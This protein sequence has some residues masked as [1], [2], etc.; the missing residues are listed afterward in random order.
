MMIHESR[1]DLD[2][3]SIAVLARVAHEMRQPLSAATA[4]VTLIKDD[5]DAERVE[6]AYRVLKYQ[7]ARLFRLLDDL[8]VTATIGSDVTTLNKERVDL[9]RVLVKMMEGLRL[10]AAQKDQRL[11]L[12][13]SAQACWID[14]DRVR[15]DQV[16]S[17]ILTNAIKYTDPGGHIW[18]REVMIC[19]EAV[20]TIGDTGQGIPPD[21]L[22]RVFETFVTGSDHV[23]AGLGLGLAVARHLVDLHRGSIAV[24]SQGHGRGTEVTVKQPL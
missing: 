5:V 10:L 18:V 9:D 13:L 14:A 12:Q 16:F 11:E 8:L 21:M 6:R 15:L 4:A 23:R 20:V 22:P 3:A 19:D 1:G 2:P 24:V 17:N 7:C